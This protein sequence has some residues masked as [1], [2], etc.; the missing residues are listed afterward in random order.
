MKGIPRI[1]K[2]ED[3]EFIN[4][5]R[6]QYEKAVLTKNQ[7]RELLKPMGNVELIIRRFTSFSSPIIMRVG[8]GKYKFQDQP[9]YFEKMQRAWESRKAEDQKKGI[10]LSPIQKAIS[11]LKENGFKILQQDFDL[12]KALSNP[13]APV[14]QFIEWTEM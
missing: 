11:L 8:K 4:R 6:L 14:S 12:D 7:L 1:F 10:E 9:I 5:V 3:A 2:K 13:D